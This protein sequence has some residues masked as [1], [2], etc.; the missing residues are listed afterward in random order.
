[1]GKEKNIIDQRRSI[2]KIN[3]KDEIEYKNWSLFL[4]SRD[5]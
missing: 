4:K 1:M 3:S 2:F 5:I